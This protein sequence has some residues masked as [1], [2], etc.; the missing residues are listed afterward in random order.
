MHVH[1]PA[2]VRSARTVRQ[3]TGRQTRAAARLFADSARRGFARGWPWLRRRRSSVGPSLRRVVVRVLGASARRVQLG[4]GVAS[5]MAGY[6][7]H[8]PLV[9][10]GHCVHRLA[11]ARC[12]VVVAGAE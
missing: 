8:A 4:P 12:A 10:R 7:V 3:T 6:L 9:L 5:V 11:P 2:T 1:G